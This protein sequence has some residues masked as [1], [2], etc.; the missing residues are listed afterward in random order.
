MT[1]VSWLWMAE[2]RSDAE[3]GNL[4]A[5]AHRTQ[6]LPGSLSAVV[7]HPGLLCSPAIK[8]LAED[9]FLT[10]VSRALRRP[11]VWGAYPP[12]MDA[13]SPSIATP[14]RIYTHRISACSCSSLKRETEAQWAAVL[15]AHVLHP[16]RVI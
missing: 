15:F 11:A 1:L 2:A 3:V 7:S 13:A 8:S 14:G 6:V 9:C 5:P 4:E 16:S 10:L 12:G